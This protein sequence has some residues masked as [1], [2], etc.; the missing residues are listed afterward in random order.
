MIKTLVTGCLLLVSVSFLGCA[1]NGTNISKTGKVSIERIPSEKIFIPWA[2]VYQIEK[3][4]VLKGVIERRNYSPGTVTS[5][6]DTYM[7][8]T[9]QYISSSDEIVLGQ[10]RVGRGIQWKRFSIILPD[11]VVQEQIVAQVHLGRLAE[12][13]RQHL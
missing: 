1:S 3:G 5:H 7:A 2:D 12:C 6:V 9:K 4:L 13:K 11:N 8:S 10:K